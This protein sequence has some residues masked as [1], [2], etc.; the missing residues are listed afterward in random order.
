MRSIFKLNNK[1]FT[2]LELLIVISIVGVITAASVVP[3]NS[4]IKRSRDARRKVDIEQLRAALELY[5]SNSEVGLYPEALPDL[6]PNYIQTVPTDPQGNDYEY[7]C[8]EECAD[9]SLSANLESGSVYIVQAGSAL[10]VI[11]TRGGGGASVSPTT[12]SSTTAPSP[13]TIACAKKKDGDLCSSNSECCSNYCG[14]VDSIGGPGNDVEVLG[15]SHSRGKTLAAIDPPK[16]EYRCGVDPNNTR[17]TNTPIPPTATSIPPSPTPTTV[18][19]QCPKGGTYTCNKIICGCYHNACDGLTCKIMSG[20]DVNQ[21]E[22][23]KECTEK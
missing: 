14:A 2:L 17:T 1:A 9:Y 10:T 12:T 23:D 5:K 3:Y 7:E 11:P 4:F 8:V 13:T 22:T 19:T 16:E 18:Q 6:A 20:D 15:I 21:C